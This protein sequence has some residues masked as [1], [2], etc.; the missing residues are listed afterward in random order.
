MTI[1]QVIDN[2]KIGTILYRYT[3]GLNKFKLLAVHK[4][5]HTA[6]LLDIQ[7]NSAWAEYDYKDGYFLTEKEAVDD[8]KSC[9]KKQ[10]DKLNQELTLLS[11]LPTN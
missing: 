3:L 1:R 9:I 5:T 11:E 8:R 10:I 4:D 6:F 2:C 7:T